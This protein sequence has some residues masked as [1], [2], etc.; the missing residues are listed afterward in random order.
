MGAGTRR[1]DRALGAEAEL[2]ST[3]RTTSPP[4]LPG[5]TRQSKRRFRNVSRKISIWH[6][7]MD[8]RVKPA[9]DAECAEARVLNAPA[10]Q[11]DY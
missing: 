1:A 6:L 2:G 11:D 5:S 3:R 8:A 4:S 10:S 9:H 7:I